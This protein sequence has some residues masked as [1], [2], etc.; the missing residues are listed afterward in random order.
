MVNLAGENKFILSNALPTSFIW[1]NTKLNSSRTRTNMSGS[2]EIRSTIREDGQKISKRRLRHLQPLIQDLSSLGNE[3]PV[4]D[5]TKTTHDVLVTRLRL[6]FLRLIL[7]MV[8]RLQTSTMFCSVLPRPLLLR[9]LGEIPQS[10][11]RLR[12]K[13]C[14]PMWIA[15]YLLSSLF[16][17][18][19]PSKDLLERLTC[20]TT[21]KTPSHCT[22]GLPV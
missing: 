17:D 5:R 8:K 21:V 22:F 20:V 16:L 2:A 10:G 7:S 11:R 6:L 19:S 3:V 18:P 12:R 1:T 4:L 13:L 14:L 9:H 15:P